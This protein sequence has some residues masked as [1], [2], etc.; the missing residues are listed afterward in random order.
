MKP[1]Y[2]ISDIHAGIRGDG[3]DASKREAFA[4]V[5]EKA[6]REAGELILLGDVF[7]FWFQWREVVPTRHL[8][9][10]RLL[11]E[12]TESGLPVSLFPGNHDFMLEG[13]L[14]SQIGLRLPGEMERRE[15]LG[16]QVLLHHGDGLDARDKGYLLLRSTLRSRWA[17]SAFR[18]LHPDLGM[19]VADRMGAGD[20]DHTWNRE[21]LL[22]YLGRALPAVLEPADE[23]L[24][25]GHV[26]VAGAFRW[27]DCRVWT[28]PPFAHPARGYGVFDGGLLRF[29]YLDQAL[30]LEP[31]EGI[32]G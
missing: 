23:H 2:F 17:Q 19:R 27:K 32:L 3:L 7:D 1:V 9:W 11:A 13:M 18:W 21:E 4:L 6:R 29:E 16:S 15:L 22:D 31:E 26:H 8:P 5:L 14:E 30:A 12:T 24:M 20:R 28:L 25:M 10:L